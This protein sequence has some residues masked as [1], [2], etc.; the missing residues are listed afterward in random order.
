MLLLQLLL[1]GH[2]PQRRDLGEGREGD[3]DEEGDGEGEGEGE[4][5]G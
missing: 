4:G 5:E 1:V 3:G 2:P